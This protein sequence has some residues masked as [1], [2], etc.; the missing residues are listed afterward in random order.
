MT[1][2]DVVLTV[3]ALVFV[4]VLI[5]LFERKRAEQIERDTQQMAREHRERQRPPTDQPD[6]RLNDRPDEPPAR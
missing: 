2:F 6:H 1:L 5:L 3:V 4:V